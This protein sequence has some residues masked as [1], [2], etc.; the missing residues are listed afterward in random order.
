MRLVYEL[1]PIFK[2]EIMISR[3]PKK[4]KQLKNKNVMM[5]K[6]KEFKISLLPLKFRIFKEIGLKSNINFLI[7]TGL[8]LIFYSESQEKKKITNYQKYLLNFT[9]FFNFLDI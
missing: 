1:S 6:R 4:K 5:L 7:S 9:A 3:E 8:F 2:K